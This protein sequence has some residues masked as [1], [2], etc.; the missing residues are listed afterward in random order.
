MIVKVQM[1]VLAEGAPATISDSNRR[2]LL[3]LVATRPLIARMRGALLGYFHADIN[4]H[5]IELGDAAPLQT[6]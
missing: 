6:W 2:V 1:A 5:E 4:A 3:E